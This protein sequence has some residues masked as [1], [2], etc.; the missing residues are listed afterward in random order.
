MHSGWPSAWSKRHQQAVGRPGTAGQAAWSGAGRWLPRRPHTRASV[1]TAPKQ[2]QQQGHTLNLHRP[3][4]EPLR[5]HPSSILC[6]H[7]VNVALPPPLGPGPPLPPPPL[8]LR[9]PLA[10][11]RRALPRLLPPFLGAVVVHP[12]SW[13]ADASHLVPPPATPPRLIAVQL[14]LL[15]LAAAVLPL[16]AAAAALPLLPAAGAACCEP[17]AARGHPVCRLHILDGGDTEDEGD[18]APRLDKVLALVPQVLDGRRVGGVDAC[19]RGVAGRQAASSAWHGR[20]LASRPGPGSG[21]PP[22]PA[23]QRLTPPGPAPAYPSA[24]APRPAAAACPGPPPRA[25]RWGRRQRGRWR[26]SR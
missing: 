1:P 4:P 21:A 10:A 24:L 26:R 15:A 17:E 18:R 12:A 22:W 9:I 25:W 23:A 19:S 8:H 2:S 20:P 14:P 13:P 16:A 5:P 11:A 6:I 3:A 7:H